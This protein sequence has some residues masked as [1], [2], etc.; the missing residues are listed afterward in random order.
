MASGITKLGVAS[1]AALAAAVAFIVFNPKDEPSAHSASTPPELTGKIQPTAVEVPALNEQGAV[2]V[3]VLNERGVELVTNLLVNDMKDSLMGASTFLTTEEKLRLTGIDLET[4]AMQYD[5]DYDANEVAA[6]QKYGGKKILLAGVIDS[7]NKDFKGDAYLVLKANNPFMGV[8]A[9]LNENGKAGASSLTKNTEIFLV[10]DSGTRVM[11]SAVARSCQQF[12]QYIDQ[13]RPS[14]RSGIEKRLQDRSSTPTKLLQALQ[15]L[16]VLGTQLP[17]ESPCFT[18]TDDACKASM[19]AFEG[20]K[21][22]VQA[23]AEQVKRTF[24]AAAPSS[25][26]GAGVE[27]VQNSGSNLGFQTYTNSRYGFRVD[28]PE[29]FVPQSGPENGDGLAFKSGDGKAE[30]IAAGGNSAGL[31]LKEAFDQAVKEVGGQL[32][33]NKRGAG[34]FVVT[35]TDGGIQGYTKEFVGTESH[36]SITITYPI[37]QKTQYDSIVAAIEKSFKPG[38]LASAH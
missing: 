3:P 32:G 25:A 10:C 14:L 33:Y 5:A 34:W 12:S 23:L 4:T 20:D 30:L 28:Y 21:A 11:G 29:S 9:E 38:D 35:W 16:Y 1:L 15:F 26:V 36:N 6:D 7:I 17:P 8:H 22:R 31:T 2:E 19:T 24:P 13:I 37:E 27:G 18:G